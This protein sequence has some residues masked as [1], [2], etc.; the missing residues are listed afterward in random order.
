MSNVRLAKPQDLPELLKL[1]EP[2]FS[3]AFNWDET[4]FTSEFAHEQT[5]VLEEDSQIK[6][7]AC[8]RDA[9]EAWELSVLASHSSHREQGWMSLLLR[10]LIQRYSKQRHFWLEVHEKNLAAQKLYEKLGFQHDGNR[11]GYYRD[12]SSALLYSFPKKK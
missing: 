2:Y 7:F 10:D 6:A 12:G 11:G 4:L 1:I 3:P 5:W 9:V 8:L